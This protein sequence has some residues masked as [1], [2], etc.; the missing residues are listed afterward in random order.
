MQAYTV[1]L[2]SIARE[3]S[4]T[5]CQSSSR[6]RFG[7]FRFRRVQCPDTIL[8]L[9]GWADSVATGAAKKQVRCVPVQRRWRQVG[10]AGPTAAAIKCSPRSQ[11]LARSHTQHAHTHTHC[12]PVCRLLI[13]HLPTDLG[14]RSGHSVSGASAFC[15]SVGSFPQV[16]GG[17]RGHEG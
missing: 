5:R 2:Y 14:R 9:D 16:G 6:L 10:A 8:A 1:Q 13:S 15:S 11:P 12:E 4:S 17:G 3:G 7:R